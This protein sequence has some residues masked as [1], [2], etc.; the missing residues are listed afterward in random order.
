MDGFPSISARYLPHYAN[1]YE[2]WSL[3]FKIF[4]P[5]GE[6]ISKKF[7]IIEM[8]QNGD[9][10]FNFG[11]NLNFE[12]SSNIQF[13]VSYELMKNDDAGINQ[14]LPGTNL[15]QIKTVKI[16]PSIIKLEILVKLHLF[17]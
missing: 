17:K 12:K 5:N 4:I 13:I 11:S 3:N 1:L 15:I 8:K 7:N 9:T 6:K 16:D 10:I 2:T 14:L